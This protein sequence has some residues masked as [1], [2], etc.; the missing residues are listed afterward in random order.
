VGFDRSFRVAAVVLA[1][2]GV[3]SFWLGGVDASAVAP[4]EP[5]GCPFSLGSIVESGAFGNASFS[6]RVIPASPTEECTTRV[7]L[8]LGVTSPTGAMVPSAAQN[9][10]YSTAALTFSPARLAPVIVGQW[11]GHCTTTGG[12]VV[13]M[14]G[15]GTSLASL[16]EDVP[17]CA[18]TGT[19]PPLGVSIGSTPSVVGIAAAPGD[20][21]YRIITDTAGGAEL[22]TLGT[23][24][25]QHSASP[26]PD[27][28][29]ISA[30]PTG[31]GDWVV[32]QA[33][34]I[35]PVGATTPSYGDL[36]GR[37]INAPIVGLAADS[38]TGG[39]W[40]VG[41]DGGVYSFDAPF[42]GSAGAIH[43]NSPVVGITA[44]P[45]GLGY[46]LVAA[47]GGVFAYGDARF[48]GSAGSI[49]LN[50]PVVG[51]TADQATGGYWIVAAD[52]GVFSY[53]APFL[54]SAGNIPL[55]AGVSGIAAT[56][57]GGG[58]WLVAADGGI[59]TYGNAHFYGI[60][61]P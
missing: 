59:F 9:P 31:G 17:S 12:P 10:V 34:S 22:V 58:Y 24:I 60:T 41:A 26:I 30:T 61:N 52:G 46:W 42:Y 1:A 25:L 13:V 54:G 23:P 50:S 27:L 33:G 18:A 51:I 11:A 7:E 39:Y 14:L 15:T 38:A 20:T 3:T 29:G 55:N 49:H 57:S 2:V 16:A 37:R 45:D 53:H 32:N 40:L 35:W 44:T 43:L 48:Y 56:A 28:V 6:T 47:D 4:P 36:T 8:S 21:G 5:A 19:S